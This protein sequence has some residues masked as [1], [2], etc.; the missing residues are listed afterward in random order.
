MGNCGSNPKTNEGPEAVPEPV[1]EEV[2]VEQK[3][4]S[5]ANVETKL[6]DQTPNDSEIKSLGTLLNEVLH[7]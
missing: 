5:E 7:F 1:I 2:K 4:S 3:E 6:K